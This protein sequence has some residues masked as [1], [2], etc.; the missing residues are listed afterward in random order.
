MYTNSICETEIKETKV[1][2]RLHFMSS[3]EE[4]GQTYYTA[5]GAHT[6][7]KLLCVCISNKSANYKYTSTTFK[8]KFCSVKCKENLSHSHKQC[9]NKVRIKPLAL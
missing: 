6:G 1:W 2:F 3:G 5:P 4:T 8:I 9:R 7:S